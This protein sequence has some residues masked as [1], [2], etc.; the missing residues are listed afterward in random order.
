[1][2]VVRESIQIHQTESTKREKLK[3]YREIEVAR[4]KASEKNLRE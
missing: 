1:M 3:T 4:I 2:D